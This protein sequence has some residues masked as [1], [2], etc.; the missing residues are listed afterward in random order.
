MRLAIPGHVKG[1]G[2]P[3]RFLALVAIGW[4]LLRI[5]FLWPQTGSLPEA[6]RAVLPLPSF[7]P[8]QDEGAAP[9]EPIAAAPSPFVACAEAETFVFVLI[10]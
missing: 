7:G 4:V 6:I 10:G 2:R 9:A 1:H 3:L 8:R 5:A